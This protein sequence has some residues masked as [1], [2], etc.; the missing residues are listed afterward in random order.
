MTKLDGLSVKR[1]IV[2][3]RV[4]DSERLA[5]LSGFVRACFS[6]V[7]RGGECDLCLECRTDFVRD[8]V[9]ALMME[10][11]KITPSARGGVSRIS[12]IDG[13]GGAEIEV[14]SPAEKNAL[15]YVGSDK[16]LRALNVINPNAD[17][18][19]LAP[20]NS[21][22]FGEAG[23]YV[24]GLFLGCGSISVPAVENADKQRS[25]GYHLEFS[26][27]G[28]DAASD[29]CGIL[30][31]YDIYANVTLRAEK[32]V[33]Y[34]KG[35]ESVSDCLALIGAEKTVLKLN[36]TMAVLAVKGDVTRRNNCDL[37]NMNRAIDA[38]VG[39]INAIDAIDRKVGL[40]TLDKKLYEAAIARRE[41]PDSSIGSLAALLGISKSGLKHR[42]DKIAEIAADA[43]KEE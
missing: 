25:G 24:R 8:Y 5:L 11:F 36:E 20:M 39:I 27:T 28:N 29:L 3:R 26:F 30:G 14:V 32:F 16:L 22:A 10:Q 18:F 21:G 41:N 23:C 35:G 37:A 17:G 12:G 43:D 31:E 33:V 2:G 19:E 7:R 1:E 6:V 34:V 4:K 42:L 9:A 40:K 38:S 15:V 13:N